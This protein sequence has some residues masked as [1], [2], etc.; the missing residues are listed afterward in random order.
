MTKEDLQQIRYMMTEVIDNKLEPINNR[1]GKIDDRIDKIEERLDSIDEQ[2]EEIKE[3]AKVT[4]VT[5]NEISNW[6]E[7]NSSNSNPYPVDKFKAI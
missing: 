3:D 5:V 4:R 2:L 7:L 6:V 1:L